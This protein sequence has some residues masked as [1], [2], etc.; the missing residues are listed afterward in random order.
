MSLPPGVHCCNR[1]VPNGSLQYLTGVLLLSNLVFRVKGL[2]E[3]FPDNLHRSF[4]VLHDAQTDRLV[5]SRD[6]VKG[7]SDRPIISGE[8]YLTL[9]DFCVR[10]VYKCNS[11]QLKK[12]TFKGIYC[13][14]F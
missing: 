10:H 3:I 2:R 12:R 6:L 4:L 13:A 5:I 1:T 8:Q 11:F 7:K 14:E 9:L